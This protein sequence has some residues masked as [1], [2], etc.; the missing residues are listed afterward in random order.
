MSKK[1]TTFAACKGCKMHLITTY[2]KIDRAEWDALIRSSRTGTWFQ[3]PNAYEFYASLPS[4]MK[5]FVVAVHHQTLRAICVGYITVSTN[6]FMQFF[7]RRAII[8]GGPTLADDVTENEVIDLMNAV[9]E[10]LVSI[11]PKSHSPIYIETRNF[12]DYS[13]WRKAFEQAGFVYQPHLNFHIDTSSYDTMRERVS[14][15]RSRQIKKALHNGAVIVEATSE[16]EVIAFYYLLKDLYARKVKRPLFPLSFFLAFYRQQLGK[17]LVVKYENKVIGGMMCPILPGRTIYEW[18]ICGD[19]ANY[20]AQNPSVIVTWAAMDYAA[21]NGLRRFDV[22]GAGVPDKPY[23]VREFKA[24]F[25]GDLVEHGRWLSIQKPILFAI[26]K[27]AV[28]VVG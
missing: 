1:K 5:P 11:R 3:S 13:P 19:D 20:K 23:G 17:Y 8:I 14:G 10:R 12:N 15:N 9:R 6:A 7:T 24:E 26:G 16:E 25:G 18:F 22:M 2:D 21:K 27:L 4:V 28:R